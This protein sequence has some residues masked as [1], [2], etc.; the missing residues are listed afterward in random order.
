MQ[1]DTEKNIG[2]N[3]EISV[4]ENLSRETSEVIGWRGVVGGVIALTAFIS[5]SNLESNA[6]L[7]QSGKLLLENM[8]TLTV[9][10]ILVLFSTPVDRFLM[11]LNYDKRISELKSEARQF[12]E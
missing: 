1:T 6:G 3:A 5:F 7:T 2:S 12:S 8:N 9:A 4:L 11:K 10:T